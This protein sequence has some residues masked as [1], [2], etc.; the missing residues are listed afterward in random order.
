MQLKVG[1]ASSLPRADRRFRTD[2]PPD[3]SAPFSSNRQGHGQAGCTA[4]PIFRFRS[5]RCEPALFSSA[6]LPTCSARY[7][8]INL[9]NPF[10]VGGLTMRKRLVPSSEGL[11]AELDQLLN[12]RSV[13][14]W[15]LKPVEGEG[16]ETT[17]VLVVV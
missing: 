1:R 15:R 7:G 17:A 12:L 16:Q 14:N 8:L 9:K 13:A 10:P 5:R 6:Q 3:T 2:G 4:L 11:R